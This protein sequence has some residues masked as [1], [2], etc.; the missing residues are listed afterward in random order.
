M[1][2][3]Q[4]LEQARRTPPRTRTPEQIA[5]VRASITGMPDAA[6]IAELKAKSPTT[7]NGRGSRQ[8]QREAFFRARRCERARRPGSHEW[9]LLGAVS[10]LMPE[11]YTTLLHAAMAGQDVYPLIESSLDILT[12]GRGSRR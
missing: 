6:Q 4:E 11:A 1:R 7:A 5:L 2:A 10:V 8:E 12:S 3:L 9:Q